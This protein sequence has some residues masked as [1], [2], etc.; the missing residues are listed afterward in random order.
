MLIISWLANPPG[1]FKALYVT[2]AEALEVGFSG[3]ILKAIDLYNP[4]NEA[5]FF[6]QYDGG[7]KLFQISVEPPS[8]TCEDNVEPATDGPN[9]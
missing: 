6:V 4:C 8:K 7:M 3:E 9:R 1:A 5:V 2:A